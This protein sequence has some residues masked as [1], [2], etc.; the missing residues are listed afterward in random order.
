LPNDNIEWVTSD[1]IRLS[2]REQEI[3][4]LLALGATNKFIAKELQIA[5]K[6]VEKHM[7]RIYQKLG[8]TSHSEAA[9]WGNEHIRDFPY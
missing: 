2:K 5:P 9:L 7:E 6:T 8:V 1:H 4:R 3:L